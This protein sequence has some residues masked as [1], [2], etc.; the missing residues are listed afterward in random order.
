[1]AV[2]SIT[3]D[4]SD[5]VRSPAQFHVT[6][7]IANGPLESSRPELLQQRAE[8]QAEVVRPQHDREHTL[9]EGQ[10]QKADGKEPSCQPEKPADAVL[11]NAYSFHED[12][13]QDTRRLATAL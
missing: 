5:P 8:R 4:N 11:L 13:R 12:S 1:M 9:P 3:M 6:A 2:S 10:V 7:T